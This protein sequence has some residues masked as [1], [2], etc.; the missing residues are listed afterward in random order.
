MVISDFSGWMLRE[1]ICFTLCEEISTLDISSVSIAG[2]PNLYTL[3]KEPTKISDK[4]ISN[5][6]LYRSVDVHIKQIFLVAFVPLWGK[7]YF[8]HS[9]IC[10]GHSSTSYITWVV[11]HIPF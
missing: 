2:K 8:Y 11:W 10:G 9:H 5:A 4:I 1:I 7:L 6:L 3:N